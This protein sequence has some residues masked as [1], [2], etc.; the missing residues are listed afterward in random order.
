MFI[1]LMLGG[2]VNKTPLPSS[3][4][5]ENNDLLEKYNL[6]ISVYAWNDYM[7]GFTPRPNPHLNVIFKSTSD[8][9]IPNINVWAKIT[10]GKN[11]LDTML[12]CDGNSPKNNFET[13]R[14]GSAQGL[15]MD[16][17]ETLTVVVTFEIG[18]EK[19]TLTF[20]PVVIAT[21]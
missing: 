7:P 18:N 10:S 9:S 8:K 21:H 1:S 2:C 16:T 4:T 15:K 13:F 3:D 6:E 11:T 20:Y 5:I 14:A 19:Q 17:G 12:T